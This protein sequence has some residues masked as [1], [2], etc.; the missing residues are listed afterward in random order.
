[1][2]KLQVSVSD[3]T[4]SLAAEMRSVSCKSVRPSRTDRME[5]GGESWLLLLLLLRGDG[6]GNAD[7]GG[8][9]LWMVVRGRMHELK[10]DFG[11]L[12]CE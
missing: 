11:S 5:S 12:L 3:T 2:L 6:G 7:P 9:V 10:K 4:S 1:M 8:K